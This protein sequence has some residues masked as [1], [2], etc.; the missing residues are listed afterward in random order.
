MI[1]EY[2]LRIQPQIAYNEQNLTSYIAKEKGLDARTINRVRIL[3][4]S[5]DARQRQVMVNLKVRVYIN[6]TLR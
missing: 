4:R 6:S 3:R 1:Q 5:I 2:Q